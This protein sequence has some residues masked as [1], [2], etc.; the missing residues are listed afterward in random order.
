MEADRPSTARRTDRRSAIARHARRDRLTGPRRHRR[1]HP[2]R[3]RGM[4]AL[5]DSPA[6]QIA[7]HPARSY[8]VRARAFQSVAGPISHKPAKARITSSGSSPARTTPAC[9]AAASTL[10]NAAT[11]WEYVSS[12]SA[13]QDWRRPGSPG[14]ARVWASRTERGGPP[15]RAARRLV[16]RSATSRSAVLT[17]CR[18]SCLYTSS[19]RLSRMGKCRMNFRPMS[20]ARNGVFGTSM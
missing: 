9:S 18:T 1:P 5:H 11:I 6:R 14:R 19:T 17:S 20:T 4:A 15:I 16:S 3:G 2:V 10:P 12:N 13:T 7:A 8:R